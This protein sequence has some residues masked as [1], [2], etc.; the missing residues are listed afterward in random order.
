MGH[1]EDAATTEKLIDLMS[2]FTG[3]VIDPEL[4]AAVTDKVWQELRRPA[5]FLDLN[6]TQPGAWGVELTTTYGT[7]LRVAMNGER[8]AYAT[9]TPA[10]PVLH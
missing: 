1:R 5:V 7:L 10:P 4:M 3:R 6:D 2:G 9:A 8:L